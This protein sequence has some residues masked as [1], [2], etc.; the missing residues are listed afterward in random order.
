MKV[1]NTNAGTVH[2]QKGNSARELY[3]H[4][5]EAIEKLNEI[6]KK[7][8]FKALV[9]LPTGGGKTMTA[10]SWLLTNA[11]D[12][13][14]KVLWVAHR[15]LLLEQAIS[16]FIHNAYMDKLFN[17]TQYNYRIVSGKHDKSIHISDKDDILVASK[18]SL[19]RKLENLDSFLNDQ[20]EIFLVIDEAHHSTAKSY[21]K[22]IDYLSKK[23]L[24]L[25]VIG[26]T[27]TPFRTSKTEEG[28]LGQIFPDD[29]IYK[30]DLS[31][32][33]K[34]GILSTPHTES[35][36]TELLLGDKLGG[37]AL[38]SIQNLDALPENIT[39]FMSKHKVRNNFIV[40]TFLD[41]HEKYGQTLVFA[42]SRVHGL[43]LKALFEEMAKERG[44]NIKD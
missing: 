8:Q 21:R 23:D 36:K 22:I 35:H 28:L 11:T 9:V 44:L 30:T 6:N 17:I 4:Q 37:N 16:A 43:T 19:C 34:R 38:R 42:L 7:D 25:K 27:A 3:E 39:D 31:T 33:I 40:N 32:L 5:Q 1:E 29:I 13:N 26:L 14:I 15:H 24:K 2:V 20:Q 18:D 10:S 41:H 12:K